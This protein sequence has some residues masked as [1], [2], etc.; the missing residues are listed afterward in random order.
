VGGNQTKPEN[1]KV[2][3]S[4]LTTTAASTTIT[5]TKNNNN[6][7]QRIEPGKCL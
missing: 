5:T 7:T 1:Q 2:T 4:K 3:K 6:K